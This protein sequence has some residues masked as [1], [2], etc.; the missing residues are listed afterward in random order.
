MN[1]IKIALVDQ[2]S[3]RT[4]ENAASEFMR[5]NKLKNLA[6]YTLKYYQEN[7]NFFQNCFPEIKMLKE[8]TP[9]IIQGYIGILMDKGDKVTAINAR[10]RA[11]FVFL[12]YCFEKD[13]MESFEI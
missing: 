7:L 12:R 11:I 13:W 5:H 6:P 4:I 9:E 2:N 10:L 3:H 8:I 1:R